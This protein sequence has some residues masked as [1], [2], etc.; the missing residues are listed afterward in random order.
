M[1]TSAGRQLTRTDVL[2]TSEVAELLGIPRSTVH[3]L[4]R[5]GDLPA[6]RIGRRWVFLRDRLAAAITPLDDPT[7]WKPKKR[8]LKSLERYSTALLR[9]AHDD[10]AR[11]P[12]TKKSP[13]M[14]GPLK[15]RATKSLALDAKTK[16]GKEEGL[17]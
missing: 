14:Q 9:S 4:A 3:E 13:R 5:R 8:D 11:A 17:G 7:A 10:A 15:A 12:E 6:R 1:A 2:S 16:P